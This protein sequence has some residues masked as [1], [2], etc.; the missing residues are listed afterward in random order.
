MAEDKCL[1]I[2]WGP[3]GSTPDE[4]LGG[5]GDGDNGNGGDPGGGDTG[6]GGSG[7]GG[8]YGPAN[9]ANSLFYESTQNKDKLQLIYQGDEIRGRFLI[10]FQGVPATETDTIIN[11]RLVD[12]RFCYPDDAIW[13]G[14]W[15]DGI[16]DLGN[17]LIEVK[18]PQDVSDYLRRGSFM[19]T[20]TVSD[21][22]GRG[23]QTM[24]EGYLLVEY[25][26]NSPNPEIPYSNSTQNSPQIIP[27]GGP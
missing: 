18:M 1:E 13:A 14:V 19:Y 5:P 26:A 21:K 4:D 2:G 9:G 15:N 22:L 12:Q 27:P 7:G 10:T 3:V 6:L 23:R 11:F 8:F 16:T 17:G 24:C 20:I 25:S